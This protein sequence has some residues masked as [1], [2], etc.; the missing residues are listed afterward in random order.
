LEERIAALHRPPK[1]TVPSS[2]HFLTHF[3]LNGKADVRLT[4]TEMELLS[5]LANNPAQPFSS[6]QLLREVWGYPDGAGSPELV[7]THMSNLRR[8]LRQIDPTLCQAIQTI[9]R[10]GYLM[11]PLPGM[12]KGTIF[13]SKS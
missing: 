7:R 5:Q 12:T 4:F 11:S 3:E 10:K 1:D 2:T 8:K 6:R 9:P 13:P